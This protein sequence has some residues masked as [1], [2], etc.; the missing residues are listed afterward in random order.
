MSAVLRPR[1]WSHLRLAACF[2][3][4]LSV[5]GCNDAGSDPNAQIGAKLN[6]PQLQQ[7]L[8]PPMHI[9]SVVGWKENETPTVA[10]GLQIKSLASGLQH[11]RSLY[12]LPNGDVLVVE[13][14]GAGYRAHQTP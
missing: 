9:A 7:F 2:I 3:A 8:L 13:I 12:A 11:P 10:D 14:K 6:L 5:A 4:S 1:R